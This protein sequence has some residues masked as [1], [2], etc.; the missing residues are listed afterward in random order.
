MANAL[1]ENYGDLC[2]G[3]GTHTLPDWD[4]HDIRC[5]ATDHGV[6]TPNLVTHQDINDIRTA[7]IAVTGDLT[8]GVTIANGDVDIADFTFT[9]VSGNSI[10]SLNFYY[11]TGVDTTSTL[12]AYYDT[13]TGLPVTPN[14]GDIDVAINASG[15]YGFA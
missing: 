15:L 11:H 7:E 12:I 4:A 9:T 8:V 5:S 13:A 1:Y 10:E 14:G 6:V 3:G 2:L